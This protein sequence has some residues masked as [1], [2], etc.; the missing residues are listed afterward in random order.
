LST[1]DDRLIEVM[2]A[3]LAQHGAYSVKVLTKAERPPDHI[4]FLNQFRQ[5][6]E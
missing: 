3:L 2:T 1:T 4:P 5:K 6:D